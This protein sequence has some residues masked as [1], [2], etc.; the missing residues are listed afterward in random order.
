MNQE[1]S[2]VWY[3]CRAGNRH[4][5]VSA[6]EL[7][8][9][10]SSDQLSPDDLVWKEGIADWVPAKTVKG[11]FPAIPATSGPPPVSPAPLPTDPPAAAQQPKMKDTIAQIRAFALSMHRQRLGVG[12]AG[13]AGAIATFL[14][15]THNPAG[16]VL[17]ASAIYGWISLALFVPAIVVALR[18][19]RAE[20]LV[21]NLR[22][23]AVVPA[24]IA[25]L[26]ALYRIIEFKGVMSS[27]SD[28]PFGRRM[29]ASVGLGIGLYV[30]VAAGLAVG[31]LAWALAA[32]P[33]AR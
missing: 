32:R 28:N 6:G 15:W 26:M 13:L 16:S 19:N 27:I 12:I 21:G 23:G 24:G 33:Q 3:Y 25:S 18:G 31:A 1:A 17:G 11:L 2:R 8:Q 4:G 30:I 10:A 9:L 14:P 22:L 20:P 7:K 29:A 5:P